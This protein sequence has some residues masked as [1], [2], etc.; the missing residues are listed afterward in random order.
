M[1]YGGYARHRWRNDSH[2]YNRDLCGENGSVS[3]GRSRVSAMA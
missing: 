2:A 3:G 1:S